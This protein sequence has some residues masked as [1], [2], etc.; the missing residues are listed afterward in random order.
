MKVKICG[1]SDT[2]T[3]IKAAEYGADALGFVFARSKRQVNVDQVKEI[4]S[5]IPNQVLKVGVFV[6]ETPEIIRNIKKSCQLDFVQL[7]GEENY[8]DYEEFSLQ[9][10]KAFGIKTERDV[11]MAANYPSEFL[12]L[13]SP[14]GKYAGGNGQIFNW[15]LINRHQ[16]S[17]KK[18][19]LAGGLTEANVKTAITAV[20]PYMV[21]I[22][23]G[24]ETN[25]KKD[26]SKIK[27]FLDIV[28][29]NAG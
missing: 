25:G 21:D 18:I 26:I 17:N 3:A 28:K 7:H 20:D 4:V 23:S 1:I 29:N 27:R 19:I 5:N 15:N 8:Y 22:S 11:Q 24:V 14:K 10:I 6:N 2:Y 9:L 12:L 13:D 16:F